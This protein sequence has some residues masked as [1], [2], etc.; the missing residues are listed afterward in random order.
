MFTFWIPSVASRLH[1]LCHHLGIPINVH[2]IVI[3][4]LPFIVMEEQIDNRLEGGDFDD[5]K[6]VR[7]MDEAKGVAPEPT[8]DP[9]QPVICSCEKRLSCDPSV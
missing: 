2:D 8:L 7:K 5:V 3:T 6:S 4:K 1:T 9:S